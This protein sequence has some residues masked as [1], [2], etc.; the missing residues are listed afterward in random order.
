M[1]EIKAQMRALTEKLAKTEAKVR[2][3]EDEKRSTATTTLASQPP[4]P[5]RSRYDGED[6]YEGAA[7]RR[8]R[9]HHS[10]EP[11][12]HRRVVEAYSEEYPSHHG[13]QDSPLLDRP[14]LDAPHHQEDRERRSRG[15]QR[16]EVVEMRESHRWQGERGGERHHHHGNR[17]EWPL[18]SHTLPSPQRDL[19]G[20]MA[21]RGGQEEGRGG[22]DLRKFLEQRSSRS[23]PHQVGENLIGSLWLKTHFIEEPMFTNRVFIN[24]R[25][26]TEVQGLISKA[27]SIPGAPTEGPFR[28]LVVVVVGHRSSKV[29]LSLVSKLQGT[30]GRDRVVGALEAKDDV[31]KSMEIREAQMVPLHVDVLVTNGLVP[32]AGRVTR[33]VFCLGIPLA[34][35]R[36]GHFMSQWCHFLDRVLV[37]SGFAERKRIMSRIYGTQTVSTQA[38]EVRR[39]FED[40]GG[41]EMIGP[42][43]R[44][45]AQF[46]NF[47][48][49]DGKKAAAATAASAAKKDDSKPSS[50]SGKKEDAKSPVPSAAKKE[51]AKTSSAATAKKAAGK[52]AST[53]SKEEKEVAGP[54][55]SKEGGDPPS[56]TVR[57][58]KEKSSS[59]SARTARRRITAPDS[60][61]VEDEGEDKKRTGV[62]AISQETK[63]GLE[64]R[65]AKEKDIKKRLATRQSQDA[66]P[67]EDESAT[68]EEAALTEEEQEK[69]TFSPVACELEEEELYDEEEEE[70]LEIDDEQMEFPEEVEEVQTGA[71]DG[72]AEESKKIP[73]AYEDSGWCRRPKCL[74]SVEAED[75][76]GLD[77]LQLSGKHRIVFQGKGSTLPNPKK[78]SGP[79]GPTYVSDSE[80]ALVHEL[81]TA[82]AEKEEEGLIL[83]VY[84]GVEFTSEFYGLVNRLEE[85]FGEKVAAVEELGTEGVKEWLVRGAVKGR[86]L[87]SS[88]PSLP[89][90][91]VVGGLLPVR[92]EYGEEGIRKVS[93]VFGLGIPHMNLDR[94]FK[95]TRSGDN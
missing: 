2:E 93:K 55:A 29:V 23:H 95:P 46:G 81:E 78:P 52:P 44:N 79:A 51:D 60:S 45:V 77:D 19:R 22:D 4:P 49:L 34:T 3:F 89:E 5:K 48:F 16:E 70:Y 11:P 28:P 39:W 57:K 86:E 87:W 74:V 56:S 12:H 67:R 62:R 18:P 58:E 32:P 9:R 47:G 69:A 30:Y 84:G 31:W 43:A 91:V 13:G 33:S 42:V 50:S 10:N 15:R 8:E 27:F 94:S 25:V 20:S 41:R 66:P 37:E 90:V 75:F 21:G 72:K 54:S 68:V 73:E 80:E 26:L 83:V 76:N 63:E 92:M 1:A 82:L 53:T 65:E 17:E 88:S 64:A 7:H 61:D 59:A 85:K 71:D 35:N 6:E 24:E 14:L 36:L 40:E 38:V